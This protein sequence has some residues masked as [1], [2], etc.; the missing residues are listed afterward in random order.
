MNPANTADSRKG[1]LVAAIGVFVLLLGTATGNAHAMLIM[2][3]I[4]LVVISII[5]RQ[6]LDRNALVAT[7]VAAAVA[8]A[9]A[10]A[11]A[12]P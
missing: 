12:R 7:I 2:A 6:Q 9:V 10:I 5:Y 1:G 11:I 8:T 3:M 4:A